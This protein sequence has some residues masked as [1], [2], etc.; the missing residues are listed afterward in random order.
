MNNQVE[1]YEN[2]HYNDLVEIEYVVNHHKRNFRGVYNGDYLAGG[3]IYIKVLN[4][5]K[6]Q[7]LSIPLKTIHRMVHV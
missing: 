5:S 4:A 2:F 7:N 6:G 3:K 1:H